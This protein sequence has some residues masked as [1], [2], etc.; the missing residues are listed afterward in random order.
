MNTLF[1]VV[2]WL[3]MAMVI[4]AFGLNS[5]KWLHSDSLAY[6]ILNGLGSAF[7]IVNCHHNGAM[8]PMVLNIIWLTIALIS[9]W[10]YFKK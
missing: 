1:D 2:G 10:N 5:M 7:L 6:I 3:G 4:S 8:P 9:L